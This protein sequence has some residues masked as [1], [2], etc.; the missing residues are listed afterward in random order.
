M[1]QRREVNKV[2][3]VTVHFKDTPALSGKYAI[4]FLEE[5]RKKPS[6]AAIR[7]NKDAQNLLRRLRK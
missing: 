5:V 1:I 7:R 2:P 6:A 3:T 4:G